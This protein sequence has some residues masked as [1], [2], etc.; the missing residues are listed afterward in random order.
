MAA[1]EKNAIFFLKKGVKYASTGIP[2]EPA[3]KV[4]LCKQFTTIGKALNSNADK[5]IEYG[6][7]VTVV[8]IDDIGI[9]I[10]YTLLA[11]GIT[12]NICMIDMNEEVLEGEHLDL[13]SS[14][15][16][17]N[18]PKI[19]SSKDPC[20]S[21]DS[22]VCIVTTGTFKGRDEDD[23]DYVT[24]N[25]GI[26]RAIVTPLANY[27]P[28]AIFILASEPVDILCYVT[29][30][31]LGVPKNRIIGT[32]TLMDTARFRYLLSDKFGV[33]PDSCHAYIIGQHGPHFSVPVW[34]SVN[35]AGVLLKDLNPQIGS[36]KDPECWFELY[37]D[38]VNAE[39]LV[40][41]LKGCVTWSL[42]LGVANICKCI[43]NNSNKILPVST[44]VKGEHSIKDEVFLSLPC[45]V[46][47][48]G[49]TNI[50]RQNLTEH[51]TTVLRRGAENTAELQMATKK[52]IS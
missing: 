34:S 10:V 35:V 29:W 42:A 20:E 46:G 41:N 51:E 7:K 8:G 33:S 17:L 52:I 48:N 16:F 6:D 39:N 15:F 28:N 2:P 9:A 11:Q 32:G 47:A 43:F 4:R 18:N 12:N 19:V 49:V 23:L 14:A 30:K 45:V 27:S 37:N 36:D 5:F 31:L 38:A 21:R 26:A 25:A 1:Y 13:Q 40:R 3:G 44:Y 50:I 24:R 22:K